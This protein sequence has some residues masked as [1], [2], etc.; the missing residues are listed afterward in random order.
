[1]KCS[2][3]FQ[4]PDCSCS[5]SCNGRQAY[6]DGFCGQELP[7]IGHYQRDAAYAHSYQIDW[8]ALVNAR[9]MVAEGV[10]CQCRALPSMQTALVSWSLQLSTCREQV[11]SLRQCKAMCVLLLG[12]SYD[13]SGT[14]G[15]NQPTI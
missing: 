11:V 14:L 10:L 12:S 7:A 15:A 6:L 9:L 3:D 4:A 2:L 8:K 1:M 13:C 5:Q